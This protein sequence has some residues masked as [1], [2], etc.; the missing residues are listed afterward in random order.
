MQQP[1]K[2]CAITKNKIP[3]FRPI[4]D[5][6]SQISS[7]AGDYTQ[8]FISG[9]NFFRN[10]TSYVNF[11]NIKNIPI[12]Y[13]S[14]FNISFIVP[15]NA[16]KGDYIVKVVNIYNGNVSLPIQWTYP[17]ILNNSDGITYSIL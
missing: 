3:D 2:T 9:Y 4:I 11:G 10:G 17:P 6:L 8:V 12:T 1:V 14:S 15:I 13:Y 7:K 16:T 5:R